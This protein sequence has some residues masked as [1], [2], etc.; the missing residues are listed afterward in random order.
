MDTVHANAWR[1]RRSFVAA[2]HGF[3]E[4]GLHCLHLDTRSFEEGFNAG[5][6]TLLGEKLK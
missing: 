6:V 2:E 5:Q 1:R 4:I 3:E